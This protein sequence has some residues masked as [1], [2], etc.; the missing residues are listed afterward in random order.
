V[1]CTVSI[2]SSCW[3]NSAVVIMITLNVIVKQIRQR[4]NSVC[5]K[6]L[7]GKSAYWRPR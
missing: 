1:H 4:N 5:Y 7:P 2:C 6:I 3:H